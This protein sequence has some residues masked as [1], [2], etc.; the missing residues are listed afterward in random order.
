[1]NAF[2]AQV[3]LFLVY[4]VSATAFSTYLVEERAE[5]CFFRYAERKTKFH[6]K[7]FVFQGGTKLDI[8]FSVRGPMELDAHGNIKYS[9]SKLGVRH[10]A[11]IG[12]ESFHGNDDNS[13]KE[14]SGY[15][16][17][18]DAE[19]GEYEICLSNDRRF[20]QVAKH[21]MLGISEVEE[22]APRSKVLQFEEEIICRAIAPTAVYLVV[23]NDGMGELHSVFRDIKKFQ[24]QERMRLTR[25]KNSAE[26]NHGSMVQS[27]V[28]ETV[29]L[30]LVGIGQIIF[31]RRMFSGKGT[32][33]KQWT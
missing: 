13:A 4:C 26:D 24:L 23:I 15:E 28:M 12:S 5:I 25:R 2:C 27:S 29:V 3:L 33:L 16:H 1:M 9:R 14:F 20:E 22:G 30:L 31:V 8:G 21:V 11:K 6:A 18:F 10:A 17:E 7:V 19:T 32:I